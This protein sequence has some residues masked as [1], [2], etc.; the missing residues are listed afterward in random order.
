MLTLRLPR[1]HPSQLAIK[2]HPARFKALACGRRWGKSTLIIDLM[3]YTTLHGHPYG[4]F[5]P[6]YKLLLEV[7]RAAFEALR[8]A[9]R[10]ANATERRLELVTGG[11]AEFW[12]LEDP[13]AGRSRKY[14]SVAVDEAGLV[15]NLL[16]VWRSAIRPTLADYAGGGIIAGT[17]KGHG[18]FEAI[19]Q[20]EQT[21]LDWKSFRRPTDDNPHIPLAE[22]ASLRSELGERLAQQ[23]IDAQFVDAADLD[24]FLPDI[25][26]W[27]ACREELP[28]LGPREPLV[29][30]VDAG[31]SS[32]CFAIIGVT[33]HPSDR[34]R[35]AVRLVRV[36][37]P[38]DRKPLDYDEIESTLGTLIN[39]YNVVCIAYDPHLL[40][41]MMQ[42]LSQRV[43]CE[44]FGQAGP[45]LE[46]D[47]ALLDHVM[48]RGLAHD[49]DDTLSAHIANADRKVDTETRKLR[50]VKRKPELKIDAAVALSMGVAQL[51]SLNV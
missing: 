13:D 51:R 37:E 2:A 34:T 12:T 19:Y 46:A 47:K 28:P 14:K 38:R 6:T 22:V 23:E 15:P 32:D 36:Y 17:P 5:A 21:N 49:G 26:L 24:R 48:T 42:R 25:Q 35:T 31:L 41:H 9:I 40:A 7:W 39:Q 11:V 3:A 20:L 50:I 10:R 8:P 33:P 44:P 18:D 1:P 16:E 30:G 45:R 4:Y 29:L 27:H 43:W